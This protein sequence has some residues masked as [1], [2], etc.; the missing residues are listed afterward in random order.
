MSK[1]LSFY[2]LG[3]T[4]LFASRMDQRFSYCC[5]IPRNYQ[6]NGDK[7]HQLV[8]LVHGSLRDADILRDE[9][10]DF[11]EEHQCLVLAPLFP[12]AIGKPGELHNYK[13]IIYEDIRYDL[14]LLDMIEEVAEQYR[15]DKEKFLL[16]GFSGGGQFV[17]RFLYLYP[18]RLLGV[19]VGAPGTV[20]LPDDQ[21][22]WW[23]GT[24]D[25]DE[26]FG[27]MLNQNAMKQVAIQLVIGDQD[28][29]TWDVTVG[30]QSAL[31]IDGINDSGETRVDRLRTLEKS[32]QKLG[33]APR[34]DTVPGVAHDGTAIQGAVKAF[35]ND[36]LQSKK[37]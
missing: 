35:F 26:I 25:T 18:N 28:I 32:L 3:R 10:M 23:V 17:H 8:V 9:F 21:K 7:V 11:A 15:I 4:P 14:I 12:C 37:A 13:R 6:P 5:Y 34:F 30:P 20:T 27:R 36:I 33:L 29:E 31:W 2:N 16:H 19:S 24:K 1:N 22:S